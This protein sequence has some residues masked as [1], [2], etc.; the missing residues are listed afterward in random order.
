MTFLL[1]RAIT[2]PVTRLIAV[3]AVVIQLVKLVAGCIP[4]ERV[5]TTL[6]LLAGSQ[7]EG[8]IV[9]VYSLGGL[10]M[11]SSGPLPFVMD[12]VIL[13]LCDF[14][15]RLNIQFNIGHGGASPV[16]IHIMDLQ[17]METD[18]MMWIKHNQYATKQSLH[19]TFALS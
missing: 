2:S 3:V 9:L 8:A 17:S 6:E 14:E 16:I 18:V 13:I 7:V 1:E 12:R 5:Y 15:Q 11:S 10:G 19:F 4:H